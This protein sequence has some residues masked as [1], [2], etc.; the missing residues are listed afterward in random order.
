MGADNEWVLNV[1]F[2]DKSLLRNYLAYATAREVMP[3]VQDC[4][5]C[6][7]VWYDGQNYQYEGVYLLMEKNKGGK[8]SG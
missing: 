1:S 5:F 6:E 8:E 7:V 3:Y 4:R 2:I